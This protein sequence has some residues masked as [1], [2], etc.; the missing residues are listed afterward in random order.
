MLFGS[1]KKEKK[2]EDKALAK[3]KELIA[4]RGV[5]ERFVYL[6]VEFAVV[7]HDDPFFTGYKWVHYPKL[8]CRY[9]NDSGEVKEVSFEFSELNALKKENA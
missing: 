2:E 5:G 4:F 3:I 6:G 9:V 1:K 7:S 8:Q